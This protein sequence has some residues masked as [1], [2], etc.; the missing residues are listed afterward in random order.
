MFYPAYDPHAGQAPLRTVYLGNLPRELPAHELMDYV[1]LGAVES[2]R[3]LDDKNCAFVLFVEPN[4]AMLFHLDAV[5]KRLT[6]RGQNVRIGWGRHCEIDP[7]VARALAEGATRNVFVGSVGKTTAAQLAADVARF[8]PV[9]CVKMVPAKG[10]AFVHF[11][12]VASAMQ[13]V[14]EL[15]A[16]PGYAG[17]KVAYGKDRCAFITKTQQHNAAQYLGLAPG[18]EHLVDSADREMI[19][20]AL[21]E[22]SMAAAAIATQAG[23]ANNLGNRTV[24][25]GNLHP[26]TTAEEVCNVVRG[27]LVQTVRVLPE[28]RICFVTFVDPILAAQFYAMCVLHGLVIHSRSI[29]VGWGKHSGPLPQPLA[30]AVASG[31]SRNVY[32]GGIANFDEFLEHTLRQDFGVFGELEQVN[33]LQDRRCAFVNFVN[34]ADAVKAVDGI[35]SVERYRG[36]KVNYGKD[37]CGNLPRVFGGKGKGRG[38]GSGSGSPASG[39]GRGHR[40]DLGEVERG[41]E[42]GVEQLL[43]SP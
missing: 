23:G 27:G 1:R 35:R 6:I 26:D 9:D 25:L 33:F 30:L 29:K 31:A 42:R 21:V 41:V 39:S 40:S 19:S 12:L 16:A 34:I 43:L 28:R 37:R 8:G 36:L 14:A 24:Y 18:N 11:L 15:G 22:Q 17:R 3:I 13:C 5:L 38:S 2:V 4:A 20:S 7:A 10:I 32:V